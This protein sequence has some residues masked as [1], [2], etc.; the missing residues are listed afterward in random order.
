MI[1]AV[2][3]VMGLLIV[4]AVTLACLGCAMWFL[5]FLYSEAKKDGLLPWIKL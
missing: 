3:I 4:A 2:L 1:A 5:L